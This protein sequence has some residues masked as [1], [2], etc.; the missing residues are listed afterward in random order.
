[1]PL[2]RPKILIVLYAAVAAVLAGFYFLYYPIP[3]FWLR[4]GEILAAFLGLFL[5]ASTGSGLRR[6]LRL[7]EG[8][9]P[10]DDDLDA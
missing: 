10:A 4:G 3:G 6:V 8:D 7:P 1:M 9:G 2:V 5:C